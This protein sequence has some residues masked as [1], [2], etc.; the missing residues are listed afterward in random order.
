MIF[1]SLFRAELICLLLIVMPGLWVFLRLFDQKCR[2]QGFI[3]GR[4]RADCRDPCLSALRTSCKLVEIQQPP[5]TCSWC[6]SDALSVGNMLRRWQN[7]MSLVH[8]RLN[9]WENGYWLLKLHLL[10][11]L[12][13]VSSPCC[14][15]CLIFI[16]LR[17]MASIASCTWMP[18]LH[19]KR[20]A[21]FY[22]RLS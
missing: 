2:F 20:M 21:P 4:C 7:T 11:G 16:C 3:R 9:G 8:G 10:C 5:P 17:N 14:L 19:H 12:L 1:A 13:I 6:G 18:G 15:S 22:T